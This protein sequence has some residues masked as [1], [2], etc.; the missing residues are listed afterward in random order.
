MNISKYL[1]VS[2][3]IEYQDEDW[4]H[5]IDYEHIPF[6]CQKFPENGHLLRDFPLNA[7]MRPTIEEKKKYAFT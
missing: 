6:W 7:P 1:L 4:T 2:I 5:T 3:T